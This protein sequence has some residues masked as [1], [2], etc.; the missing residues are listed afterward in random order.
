RGWRVGFAPAGQ[1]Y[2]AVSP[3]RA[4]GL[5]TLGEA[6]A[7]R[8]IG[9]VPVRGGRLH[10]GLP[11]LPLGLEIESFQLPEFRRCSGVSSPRARGW[12]A[13]PA[14]AA[15]FPDPDGSVWGER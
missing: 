9:R 15:S 13:E 3:R 14:E 12:P 5:A 11:K 6:P 1:P 10:R 8:G 7:T 4:E 2:R